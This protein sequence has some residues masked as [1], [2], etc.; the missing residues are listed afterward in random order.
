MGF[1]RLNRSFLKAAKRTNFSDLIKS[2]FYDFMFDFEYCF[3]FNL[4]L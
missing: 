2:L 3:T 4:V 1:I